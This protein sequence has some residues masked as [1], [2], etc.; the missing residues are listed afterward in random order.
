[1]ISTGVVSRRRFAAGL[2]IAG[3]AAAAGP[4][5][6][7]A[8]A[9]PSA[10]AAPGGSLG[11]AFPVPTDPRV[12]AVLDAD[13]NVRWLGEPVTARIS[14]PPAVGQE[15]GR[16]VSYQMFKGSPETEYPGTF[17]VTDI[18]TGALVR[19]I[20]LDTVESATSLVRAS[21]GR[22]HLATYTDNHLHVYDPATHQVRDVGA[23]NPGNP[24]AG[25]NFG[26]TAGRDGQVFA[27]AYPSANVYHYDPATD[28][29]TNLGQASTTEKYVH[30]MAYDSDTDDLY[31]AVGG[32]RASIWRWSQG[33]R[34]TLTRITSETTTPG[35]ESEVFVSRLSIVNGRLFARTKNNSLLV[36]QL[37]GTVDYWKKER[38]VVGY[39]FYAHPTDPNLVLYS[40]FGKL[41]WYDI[42]AR[43]SRPAG[44]PEISV[45]LGA[46]AWVT[47]PGND[48]QWPGV[49]IYGTDV[50]GVVRLNLT[51][52]AKEG[53]E[54][55][56]AQPTKVQ[57]LFRGPANT[58]WA[59]GYMVGLAQV[60]TTGGARYP[61]LNQGQFESGITLGETMFLG[62]Y[63]NARFHRFD[64]ASPTTAAPQ[65]FDG[66][67]EK[68]D[69][70][71][72]MAHNPD[73]NETYLG[74]VAMY[75]QHQGALAVYEHATGAHEHHTTDIV[76]SQS[77]ISV[78]Y[79]PRSRLVVI[80]TTLDGGLG[81]NPSGETAAKVVVW[82]PET[83]TRLG[84]LVPV[85]GKE[86][87]TG[88]VVGP[89][90]LVWGIAENV[91]FTFDPRSRQVVS[92]HPLPISGYA[93]NTT[94][95]AWAYLHVSPIDGNVYGTAGNRVFR[96]DASTKACTLLV[97]GLGAGNWGAID[98]RGDLYFAGLST[99]VFV[100]RVPQPITG[101]DDTQ[102]CL[103]IRATQEGRAIDTSSLPLAQQRLYE[104]I[105][106]RVQQGD[107]EALEQ[108]Y[109]PR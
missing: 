80:G 81:S 103:A 94:Y 108:E 68:Q 55:D 36:L 77:V 60:N 75:G 74:S 1:M 100:H 29:I 51:S 78:V 87:V 21:D 105:V 101:V 72:A 63:G 6:L 43:T 64:P 2:G 69:R 82:D 61:T 15:D 97:S 17:T 54:V 86:G 12:Q 25:Q 7:P 89:D 23:F 73:R 20:K 27:G 18:E 102:K 48:P 5:G 106:R 84:E 32:I 91:L 67:A 49:S 35:L 22:I 30:G 16:W 34:G 37:D 13:P 56:F 24:R 98:D 92:R 28:T 46:L 38:A 11:P 59:S 85:P 41:V 44:G 83:R 52:G 3:V 14:S 57:K 71:F 96:I 40:S 42:A 45:F 99:H 65:L 62:S 39:D 19:A 109:C 66:L 58:M 88:L 50:A 90:G 26:M 8:T 31:V 79:D 9:A 76:D 10:P 33:G 4:F 93:D 70:P 104:R 107:G 47:V 53:H 95:W